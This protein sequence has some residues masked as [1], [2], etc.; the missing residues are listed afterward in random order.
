MI[1]WWIEDIGSKPKISIP[2]I[3]IYVVFYLFSIQNGV[4]L[5][6]LTLLKKI[7]RNI[8]ENSTKWEKN[9]TTTTTT[10]F[11]FMTIHVKRVFSNIEYKGNTL[12]RKISPF[13]IKW[14][15]FQKATSPIMLEFGLE[16]NLGIMKAKIWN[17]D[18]SCIGQLWAL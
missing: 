18:P 12:C 2:F 4:I 8:V 5:Y 6:F 16:I 13:Y 9:T 3:L 7:N 1:W 17:E 14:S 11:D 10:T 15:W